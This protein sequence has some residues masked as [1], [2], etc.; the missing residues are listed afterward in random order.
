[1]ESR[2]VVAD[3]SGPLAGLRATK[4]R[5]DRGECDYPGG[6]QREP[7]TLFWC[8]RLPRLHLR[9]FADFERI[10]P[11]RVGNVLELGR[12][13]IGDREFE[14]PFDLSIGVFGEAD[15]PGRGDAL[16]P[17]GDIDAVAH[18]IAVALLDHI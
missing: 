15:R 17:G 4:T 8:G 10:D 1:M 3:T 12:A 6:Q 2:G 5:R 11:D 7:R 14:P 18:Q 16:E 9:R 13:E